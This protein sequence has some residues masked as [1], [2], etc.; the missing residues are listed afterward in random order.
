VGIFCGAG[1]NR[2][3]L[4]EKVSWFDDCKAKFWSFVGIEEITLLLG[5]GLGGPD[6]RVYWLLPGK[7]LSNGLRTISSDEDIV[8]MTQLANRLKTFVL[9]FDHD[10]LVSNNSW[11]DIV[12]YP[13]VI[14]PRKVNEIP[15]KQGEELP[16]FYHNIEIKNGS[17]VD[18]E[19]DDIEDSDF[20]D[21]N[22][23]VEDDDDLFIDYVDDTVD[24]QGGAKG[25][26]M[27]KWSNCL[28]NRDC[29]ELSIDEE[30]LELPK[31]DEEVRLART[32][33][34]LDQRI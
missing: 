22:N 19:D 6:L 14:S 34:H 33:S 21:S 5:Y 2:T 27:L 10:N 24:D 25:K 15:L 32:L 31:S 1:E 7:D 29:D 11:E 23:E 17:I 9:Y 3:Y 30:G 28:E 4:N 18:S 26:S 13:K 16:A 8:V 12:L 20:V